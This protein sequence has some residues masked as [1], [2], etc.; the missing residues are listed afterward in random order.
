MKKFNLNAVNLNSFAPR[1]GYGSITK[2]ME[3]LEY[4]NQRNDHY[5]NLGYD[6]EECAI[7]AQQDVIS[8]F[9]EPTIQ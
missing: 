2:G 1:K 3:V 9:G 4:R 6:W 7:K 5:S 8:R